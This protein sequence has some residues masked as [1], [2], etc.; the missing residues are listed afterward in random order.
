M[1]SLAVTG[2]VTLLPGRSAMRGSAVRIL[3]FKNRLVSRVYTVLAATKGS[4][5]VSTLRRAK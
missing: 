1:I 3:S 4:H 5:S 2:V